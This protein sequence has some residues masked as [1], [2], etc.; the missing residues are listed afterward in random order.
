MTYLLEHCALFM[1]VPPT[2]CYQICGQPVYEF[3]VGNTKASPVF[4]R[5]V[6]S[7][8]THN[9]LSWYLQ[10]RHRSHSRSL[11]KVEWRK[12]KAEI[13]EQDQWEGLCSSMVGQ[14]LTES[15]PVTRISDCLVSQ[16]RPSQQSSFATV[17]L[18][19]K[20]KDCGEINAKRMKIEPVDKGLEEQARHPSLAEYK[21]QLVGGGGSNVSGESTRSCSEDKLYP[22]KYVL[23][24]HDSGAQTSGM[25]FTALGTHKRVGCDH[26]LRTGSEKET[27][28]NSSINTKRGAGASPMSKETAKNITADKCHKKDTLNSIGESFDKKCVVGEIKMRDL[29]YSRRPWKEQLPQSF[30]LNHLK[31]YQAGGQRLVEAIFLSDKASKQPSEPNPPSCRQRKKRLSKRYR[32][33][34]DKFQELLRNHAKCPYPVMLKKNCPVLVSDKI[35]A[36]KQGE[37]LSRTW[38]SSAEGCLRDVSGGLCQFPETSNISHRIGGHVKL[39]QE[40]SEESAPKD[41]PRTDFLVLLKQNSSPWQVYTFVREC[42]ERVVPAALWGSSHNKCRFYKNVKKFISLGKL[43]TFPLRELL[44]KMRVN[45][46]AWLRLTKGIDWDGLFITVRDQF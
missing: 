20:R 21:D 24:E 26:A 13:D 30:V 6:Y 12:H 1:L 41:P 44:W 19:R 14:D 32:G 8:P 9:V 27:F 31:S 25:S 42:L 36:R 23:S 45:D 43:D 18:K 16:Q 4:F 34:T 38:Q 37:S 2:C 39:S 7:R 46:C 17:L 15:E 29:L 28:Q 22:M 10:G 33:M 3:P 35:G 40:Q 11:G 5:Q